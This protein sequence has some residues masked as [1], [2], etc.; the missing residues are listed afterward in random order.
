M[1]CG[2][3]LDNILDMSF[4]QIELGARVCFKQKVKMLEMVFEPIATMLGGKTKK[5]KH[6]QPSKIPDHIPPEKHDAY[7]DAKLMRSLNMAGIKIH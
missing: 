6:T 1:V 7:R 5:R 4:E 2:I 3:P